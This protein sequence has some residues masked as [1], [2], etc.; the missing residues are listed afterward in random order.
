MNW[1]KSRMLFKTGLIF[2]K[3]S[4]R[5]QTIQVGKESCMKVIQIFGFTMM[6]TI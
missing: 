5:D 4:L 2:N 3:D 6:E 1:M